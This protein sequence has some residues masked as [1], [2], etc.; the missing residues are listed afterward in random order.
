[1]ISSVEEKNLLRIKI[2]GMRPGPNL[3][4]I[5]ALEPD[6]I[7]FI[8][9]DQSPRSVSLASFA[10]GSMSF[11]SSKTDTIGVF[12]QHEL[13]DISDIVEKLGLDGVQLHGSE[14]RLY[15]E[16]LRRNFPHLTIIKAVPVAEI[17]ATSAAVEEY[18][19]IVDMML[20]DTAGP[21]LGGSGR[22]FDWK[23][24]TDLSCEVPFLVAGGIGPHNIQAAVEVCSIN[25]R[26][27]GFDVNSAVEVEPGLKS[28]SLVE[29]VI[30]RIRNV[31]C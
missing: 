30:R 20:F 25:D 9:V 21:Q 6:F 18:E 15:C 12:A 31:S 5:A 16:A 14:S 7:G 23:I 2:C 13:E 29:D 17:A 8:F 11:I 24:L 22:S 3:D 28:A 26:F 10:E 1:M 4:T 19:G 27:A